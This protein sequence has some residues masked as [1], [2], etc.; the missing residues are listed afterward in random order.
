V[1]NIPS[2]CGKETKEPHLKGGRVKYLTLRYYK[3]SK[4]GSVYAKG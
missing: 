1:E 4:S 3:E 2:R